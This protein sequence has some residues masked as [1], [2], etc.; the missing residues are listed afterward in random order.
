[1]RRDLSRFL[2]RDN[3]LGSATDTNRYLIL[4]FSPLRVPVALFPEEP[5]QL[6]G[7][8]LA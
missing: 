2:I 6:G 3:T 1:M 7:D 8:G 4:V 5:L